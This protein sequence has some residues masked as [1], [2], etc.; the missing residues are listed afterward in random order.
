MSSATPAPASSARR[1]GTQLQ[2]P[3]LGSLTA[4]GPGRCSGED[5]RNTLNLPLT[6]SGFLLQAP[7]DSAQGSR[8]FAPPLRMRIPCGRDAWSVPKASAEAELGDAV[9]C[10][11]LRGGC[12]CVDGGAAEY[13]SHAKGGISP[14]QG[15]SL[16]FARRGCG[17]RSA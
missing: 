8:R 15:S 11:M 6:F 7:T 9:R 2:A 17:R 14:Q 3:R 12:E 16:V 5:A 4:S 1:P 10:A 13:R